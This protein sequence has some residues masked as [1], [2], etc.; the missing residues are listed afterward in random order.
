MLKLRKIFDQSF[1]SSIYR[2][3]VS[4]ININADRVKRIKVIPD[5][6][7]NSYVENEIK[8]EAID[9]DKNLIKLTDNIA[10]VTRTKDEFHLDWLDSDE[11]HSL[12]VEIPFSSCRDIELSVNIKTK[13]QIKIANI[14]SSKN[15]SLVTRDGRITLGHIRS[16]N[17]TVQGSETYAEVVYAMTMDLK[18]PT[19]DEGTIVLNGCQTNLLRAIG[20][21][22]RLLLFFIEIQLLR[23]NTNIQH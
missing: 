5:E 22:V 20:K 13:G 18:G 9:G 15:I 12:I 2:N 16:E 8:V 14:P 4:V 19:E 11:T 23:P 1:L 3:Y 6:Y 21:R 7:E 17:V 10:R